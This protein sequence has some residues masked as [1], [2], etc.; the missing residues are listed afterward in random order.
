MLGR[1]ASAGWIAAVL[2]AGAIWSLVPRAGRSRVARPG[3]EEPSDPSA[4]LAEPMV[5]PGVARGRF[6]PDVPGPEPTAAPDPVAEEPLAG[7]LEGALFDD[8][9][10]PLVGHRLV[11]ATKE[12]V[13]G[14]ARLHATS[15]ETGCYEI[16]KV[17][18]GRWFAS[19]VGS[20]TSIFPIGHAAGEVDVAPG[21]VVLFDYYRP[22]TRRLEAAF[23]H[24]DDPRILLTIEVRRME[25]R[26]VLVARGVLS[27]S[28]P[29]EILPPDDLE[30]DRPP[31]IPG[32]FFLDGLEPGLYAIRVI[33]G[34]NTETGNQVYVER[35]ADLTNEDVI[36]PPESLSGRQFYEESIPRW[37]AGSSRG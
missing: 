24:A 19:Y 6:L 7:R 23:V 22:G 25:A 11:F 37:A 15:D 35:E 31:P 12:G 13:R 1:R 30:P 21:E 26:D 27:S 20:Q 3:E 4:V 14:K 17:P 28:D 2:V 9:G 8:R 36:L 16:E 18:P 10:R 32:R 5:A 34:K 33:A 29:V